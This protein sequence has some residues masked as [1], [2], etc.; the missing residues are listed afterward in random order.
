MT[1]L[2]RKEKL[3]TNYGKTAGDKYE[4]SDKHPQGFY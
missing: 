4:K 1:P 3:K 2:S